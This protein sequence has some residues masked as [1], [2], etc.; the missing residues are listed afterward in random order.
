MSWWIELNY[1]PFAKGRGG[2]PCVGQ[3]VRHYR[4]QKQD[5]AGRTWSQ[6][7]LAR[8][9][10]LTEHAVRDIERGAVGI[11]FARRHLLCA[12][13]DVPPILFGIVTLEEIKM[14]VEQ[15]R[16]APTATLVVSTAL[17]QEKRAWWVELSYPAFAPGCDGFPRTG[18][19]VKYYRERKMD[20]Q[21]H[22]YT[23]SYLAQILGISEQAI[24]DL[25]NKDAGMDFDR[26]QFLSKWLALP[27]ILLGVITRDEID[28]SVQQRRATKSGIVIV[29]TPASTSRKLTVDVQEYTALLNSSWTT[30]IN[31]P[32]QISMTNILLCRDALYRELPHVRN[33]KPLQELLCRFHNL[34]ACILRDRQKYDGALVHLEKAFRFAQQLQKDELKALVLYDY[35]FILWQAG[36]LDK[37]LQKYEEARRYERS[38]PRNLK[39]ALLLE[40]GRA[41]AQDAETP[42]KK[43]A[44]IALVDRVGNIVH[45]KEIEE[46]PY[47]L[48]FNSDRYHLTRSASL[49]A[50]GRNRDAIDELTLVKGDPEKRRQAY[51]DIEHAQAQFNLGEYSEAASFAASGLVSAQEVNSTRYIARIENLFQ[52]FLKS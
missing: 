16:V 32:A 14:R 51:Y 48:R 21:G 45:S 20:H 36:R 35:G 2:F 5:S 39:G 17:E 12:L 27:P 15:E 38:L 40:A 24:R 29:S 34:V 44:A 3:V 26:R 41:E 13:L 9:L 10:K 4:E 6:K 19:V 22:P 28:K 47:F 25:E 23:Q 33:Q 8:H 46:D 43:D 31:N 52:Q 49:I 11:D 37:A 30:F 42:E 1:P 50:V 18:E 7:D